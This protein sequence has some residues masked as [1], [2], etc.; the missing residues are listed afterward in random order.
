MNRFPISYQTKI[1]E[2]KITLEDGR[3]YDRT[4]IVEK[5]K[6]S[7]KLSSRR[8]AYPD[9]AQ[10]YDQIV[11]GEPINLNDCYLSHFSLSDLRRQYKLAEGSLITMQS[12]E[13]QH[14][15]FESEYG[16]DFSYSNFL[17]EEVS[18]AYS[19]FNHGKVNFG[20]SKCTTNFNFNRVEFLVEELSF[21]FAEFEKGNVRFSSCLFDCENVLF[22]NTNFGE[23]N[24]TFRQSDFK[25]SNCNFQYSRFDQG[26]VSFDKS[27][28]QGQT[29]DFRKIEFGGGKAD[30]RRVDFGNGN[31]NFSESEFKEGKISFRS[32]IFGNGEKKFENVNFGNNDVSFDGV[33]FEEGLL[34]FKGSNFKTLSVLDST[35]GGHCD[36]RIN[37]GELIDLSY[38]IVKDIVDFQAGETPVFLKT[39]KIE[40]LKNMGKIF[41]GWYENNTFDLIASQPKSSF[42]SK[43]S[44]F[45]LLKESFHQNGKYISE[46]KSYIAFK[47]FQMKATLEQERKK[48]GLHRLKA[49]AFYGFQWLVFDKAG[50][51]ATEPLRVFTSMI[52]VLSFFA[53][54]YAFLPFISD[55]E[56]I[57]SVGDPDHLS[58]IA[59]SFY[60]SA[61]TFFTIGYGDF[62]PSGH[63]RWLSAVEGW[64]GVF[65]MSYFTV[66]FV[67]KILR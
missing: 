43:A 16:T 62:Y 22:V 52:V 3:E 58:L 39:L 45:N 1:L 61:I 66:A 2:E 15:F 60:H 41:I 49:N 34:S 55:A 12:F 30:F 38:C 44:Q 36:F 13:A 48:G 67:R 53:L 10:L 11:N 21:K 7:S 40:G 17:G 31:L 28:F 50:L 4:A 20:H 59:K 26:D 47:R 6:G 37:Q 14:A 19:I 65:L 32:S 57:S 18:F 64:A 8:L 51:F 35:L 24:V 56:I 63:I 25:H 33:N 42:K 46:D 23:G 27:K 9:L 54:L 29:L 5:W